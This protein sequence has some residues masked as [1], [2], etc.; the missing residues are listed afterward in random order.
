MNHLL[1]NDGTVADLRTAE[2]RQDDMASANLRDYL[3][4]KSID[5]LFSMFDKTGFGMI[6]VPEVLGDGYV[7]PAS[8]PEEILSDPDKHNSVPIILGTN[9]DEP[10]LFMAQDPQHLETFLWIFPRLKDEDRYLRAVK[11]GALAWKERGVDSLASYLAASGNPHVYAYRFDWDE[12]GSVMGYDLSKALGAAHALEIAFVFGNFTEGLGLGYLYDASEEKD[13]LSNSM[14]SYWTQFA[15]TG[16]PGTGRDGSEVE[17]LSWGTDGKSAI[18]LDTPSDQGIFMMD[19]VVTK[20]TIKTALAA[21]SEITDPLERCTLYVRA[22]RRSGD[23]DQAEYDN[24]G[25]EG[26]SAFDP[27]DLDGF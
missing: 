26:C 21:D 2:A 7:L 17:W 18:I 8:S 16:S 12:E 3:Y 20:A 10:S 1:V 23:F 13:V 6:N 25:P 27:A 5:E 4:S 15:Y 14:M 24:L 9:R 19:E 22:F 11:Y